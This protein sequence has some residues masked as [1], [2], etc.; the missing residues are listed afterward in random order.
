MDNAKCEGGGGVAAP[1]VT[2]P[3]RRA[4]PAQKIAN[5]GGIGWDARG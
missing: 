1:E 5:I 4:G 2:Y 3:G